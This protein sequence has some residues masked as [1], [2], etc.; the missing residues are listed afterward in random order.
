MMCDHAKHGR[1]LEF[2]KFNFCELTFEKQNALKQ[3]VASMYYSI[4]IYLC[5]N[6]TMMI[7]NF[8][9]QLLFLPNKCK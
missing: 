2:Y 9:V 4:I 7:E 1:F 3:K 5:N 8:I 6:E